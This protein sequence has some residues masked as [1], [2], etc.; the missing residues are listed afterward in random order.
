MAK[1]GG[2]IRLVVVETGPEGERRKEVSAPPTCSVS[3]TDGTMTVTAA[4]MPGATT[5][6]WE[7]ARAK[8]LA[9]AQTATEFLKLGLMLAEYVPKL[10]RR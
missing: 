5:K 7:T 1:G 10:F 4:P 2:E 6:T 3:Y 8:V 9:R